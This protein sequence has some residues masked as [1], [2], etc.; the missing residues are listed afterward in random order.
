[1]EMI[2]HRGCAAAYPENT[3]RAVRRSGPHFPA[4]EVDVRRC[5]SG[6]VVCIHDPTVD[7]VTDDTGRVA[8]LGLDELRALRVQGSDEP[9]PPLA[10]V[11][12]AVPDDVTFQVELKE[13]GLVA[14]AAPLLD[15]VPDAL[16]ISFHVD[17][18]REARDVEIPTGYLFEGDPAENVELAAE[19]GCESVH[20]HWRTCA[21]TD[22]IERARDRGLGVYAWGG[23]TDP[24]A[25]AA[26]RDAGADGVTVDSPELASVDP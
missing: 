12:A 8:E 4:V 9:V 11:V 22:V 7:R 2:A 14:D 13:A 23:E 6:E 15:P 21:G 3:V 18:L 25:V 24:D 1:M 10:D 5:G 19:L 16:F 20:P 26:V 17:A